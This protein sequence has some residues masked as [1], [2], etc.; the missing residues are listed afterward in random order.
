M[1]AGPAFLTMQ[2]VVDI[3]RR[4]VSEFGGEPSLRDAGLLESALALPTAQFEGKFLHD[5]IPAM[6]AAYLFHLC[7]NHPFMD[8]NKRTALASA[9]I[10]L[11]LNGHSLEASD[12][13]LEALTM[14]I[15]EGTTSKQ[16]AVQFFKAHVNAS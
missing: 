4:M 5:C 16:E 13:E 9:E 3:H 12:D 14:G 6:A 11:V 7:R 1:T 8:G 10:F 2:H 15:A